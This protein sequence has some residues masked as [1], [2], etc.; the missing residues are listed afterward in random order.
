[1]VEA[2][3]DTG[4]DATVLLFAHSVH[5]FLLAI[6]WQIHSIQR[7]VSRPVQ[8]SHHVT[9]AVKL[10]LRHS[11]TLA[12]IPKYKSVFNAAARFIRRVRK[13]NHVSPLLQE[14]HWLS[15]PER[16]IK[17]RPA[18]LVFRCRHNVAP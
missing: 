11:A 6:S 15:L 3:Y 1:M 13:Y 5:H 17:H 7:S 4:S 2:F 10:G 14:I 18:V 9:C 16:I 12:G 8:P